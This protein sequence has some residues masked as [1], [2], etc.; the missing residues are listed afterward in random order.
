MVIALGVVMSGVT[1]EKCS[2]C[3]ELSIRLKAT[4]CRCCEWNHCY[5]WSTKRSGVTVVSGTIVLSGV[6]VI[7]SVTEEKSSKVPPALASLASRI[8]RMARLT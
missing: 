4:S 6:T 1:E 2:N 7:S 5:E 3:C 8:G